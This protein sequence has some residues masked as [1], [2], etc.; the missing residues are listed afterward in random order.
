MLLFLC[1]SS[2]A[3]VVPDRPYWFTLEQGKLH[4]RNGAYGNALIAFQDARTQRR[5]MYTRMEQNMIILLSLPEV[6]RF[7]DALDLIEI[8]I[9]ERGQ[10][11]ARQALDELYY[12]V[13]KASLGN[14]ARNALTR[15][16]RLKDYPEAEYWIGETYRAEGE[17]EIALRQY[18]RAYNQRELL[19]TP[20]FEIELLYKMADIHRI[21]QE[22]TQMEEK[23]LEILKEDTLWTGNNT[24]IRTAMTRT[25]E[26]DGIDRFLT[27][28]RYNNPRM[29]RAHQLLGYYYYA[30]SRHVH[31]VEHL[32]FVFLIQNSIVMDEII[33]SRFDFAYTTLDDLLAE[34]A[35]RPALSA[36][37]EETEYYKTMYY[38]GTAFLGYGKPVP[39]G[40]FW[41]A[42]SR[43]TNAGEWRNRALSQ[44][45]NPVIE[46]ALEMP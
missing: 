2:W 35:A 30:T 46:Q 18:E 32:L 39:A 41:N 11:N 13:P 20:G 6:R 36:Y 40:D 21:R 27:L 25:L 8:Y 28:Y 23:L 3:Q 26:N 19:E 33:R 14:S 17:L 22:Y 29:L 38:L 12:R 31:A 43:Q 24:F 44:L 4:F 9:E 10:I 37:F 1:F 16:S 42:L 45:R 34:A 5:D 15:L 7:R